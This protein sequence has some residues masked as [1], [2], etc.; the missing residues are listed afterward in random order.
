MELRDPNTG[1]I[2]TS[3]LVIASI[4]VFGVFLLLTRGSSSS[5]PAPVVSGGQSSG[6]TDQLGQLGQA[7]GNLNNGQ[8]TPTPTTSYPDLQSWLDQALAAA[9]NSYRDNPTNP[10]STT[11]YPSNTAHPSVTPKTIATL[12]GYIANLSSVAKPTA[13]QKAELELYKTRLVDYQTRIP[14]Q[15]VGPSSV[16]PQT[17]N[18]LQRYITNLSSVASPTQAQRAEL[19]LYKTRLSDYQARVV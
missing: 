6:L 14:A 16:S 15:T 12:Q 8:T 1:Q 4:G 11:S 5:S 17:V 10:F 7:V 9:G 13:A 2:K 19:A 3:V 18:T